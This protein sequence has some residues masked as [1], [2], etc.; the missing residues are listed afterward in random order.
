MN[1]RTG[2]APRTLPVHLM[3]ASCHFLLSILIHK[4]VA[5]SYADKAVLKTNYRSQVLPS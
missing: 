5:Y 2:L 3:F 1:T 4:Y